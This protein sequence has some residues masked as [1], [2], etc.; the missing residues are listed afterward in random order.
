MHQLLYY[1][2]S[3]YYLIKYSWILLIL[4]ILYRFYYHD[5]F[6]DEEIETQ[7]DLNS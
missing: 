1:A 2:L 3:G 4:K 7:R 6:T 5:Y